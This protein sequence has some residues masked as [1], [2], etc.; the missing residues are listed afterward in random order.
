MNNNAKK[1]NAYNGSM[2]VDKILET[3][4]IESYPQDSYVKPSDIKNVGK[5]DDYNKDKQK[6]DQQKQKVVLKESKISNQN[7]EKKLDDLIPSDIGNVIDNVFSTVDNLLS[8]T[9]K[10]FFSGK[11]REKSPKIIKP[12]QNLA[13]RVSVPVVQQTT[14]P[15]IA[16]KPQVQQIQAK[17]NLPQS[18]RVQMSPQSQVQSS[19]IKT[20]KK[21]DVEVDNSPLVTRITTI[22]DLDLPLEILNDPDVVK[23]FD[24]MKL[25]EKKVDGGLCSKTQKQVENILKKGRWGK[26]FMIS[27]DRLKINSMMVSAD[28]G[29]QRFNGMSPVYKALGRNFTNTDELKKAIEDD[30]NTYLK[31][32][33]GSGE[34]HKFTYKINRKK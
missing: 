14:K 15:V 33:E 4:D 7:Q 25:Y 34:F 28:A 3:E 21:D 19:Q 1:Y 2:D 10:F 18:T 13:P 23:Y 5:L 17:P 27:F 29:L 22:S 9:G 16:T 32:G 12:I 11:K 8:V 30:I 20:I 31:N 26:L 6:F 24:Q